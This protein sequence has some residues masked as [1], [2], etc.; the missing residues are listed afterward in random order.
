M[1]GWV[2]RYILQRCSLNTS[3]D[4][5]MASLLWQKDWEDDSLLKCLARCLS[6]VFKGWGDVD[7]WMCFRS[8]WTDPCRLCSGLPFLLTL[9]GSERNLLLMMDNRQRITLFLS[10]LE[11]KKKRENKSQFCTVIFSAALKW[12]LELCIVDSN[13][14]KDGFLNCNHWL[15]RIFMSIKGQL[16]PPPFSLW[17]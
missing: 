12:N 4:I 7:E 3:H 1:F 9:L 15:L 13:C 5:L 8:G 17:G 2:E 14:N 11:A 6:H 10:H 16:L